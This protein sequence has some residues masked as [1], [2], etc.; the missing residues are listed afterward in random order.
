MSNCSSNPKV[1][2]SV[3]GL[4][5]SAGLTIIYSLKLFNELLAEDYVHSTAHCTG[6]S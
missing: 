6:D 2:V 4:V 3:P 5:I 1:F